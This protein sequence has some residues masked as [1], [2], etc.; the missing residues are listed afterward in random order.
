M[1]LV[2]SRFLSFGWEIVTSPRMIQSK[3]PQ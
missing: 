1:H 2:S 3:K